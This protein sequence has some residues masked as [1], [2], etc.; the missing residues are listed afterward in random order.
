[1]RWLH[2]TQDEHGFWMLSL[3]ETTGETSLLAHQFTK[4]S[5]LIE[6]AREMVFGCPERSSRFPDAQIIIDPPRGQMPDDPEKW[7]TE[8]HKPAPRKAQE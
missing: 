5:H 7:P 2:I 3:E 6:H 8:Y 4:P 1:M